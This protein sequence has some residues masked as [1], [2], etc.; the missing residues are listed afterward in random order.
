MDGKPTLTDPPAR[1]RRRGLTERLLGAWGD[2]RGAA[3][4]VLA[5]RPS[6]GFLLVI[7]MTS[8]VFWLLGALA[9]LWTSN[10]AA[11]MNEDQLLGQAQ[12]LLVAGLFFRTLMLYAVAGAAGLAARLA[13]G[14]GS[15]S[16]TRAAVFFSALVAAPLLLT[17]TLL[18]VIIGP[19]APGFGAILR[20]LAQLA[21][22]WAFSCFLAEAHGF[23][24]SWP[25]ALCVTGFVALM[26]GFIYILG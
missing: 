10:E 7:A 25:V 3:R 1:P 9:E 26:L 20:T 15:Y 17:A 6:E 23:R 24:K 11:A 4:A 22:L 8:G 13:G 2:L 19:A 5:A 18:A 16:D 14:T 21:W 12:N